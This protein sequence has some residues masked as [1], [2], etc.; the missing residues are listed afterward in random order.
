MDKTTLFPQV[1]IV[2]CTILAGA[3]DARTFRIPNLLTVPLLLS[4][5]IYHSITG[6]IADLQASIFGAV[7]GFGIIFVFYLVGGMGAGD[8][9]LMAAIGAWLQ[10]PTTLHVFVIAAILM[11]LYSVAMLVWQKRL[12]DGFRTVQIVLLR[13]STIGKHIGGEDR[14]EVHVQR[15]EGYKRLIPF[16]TL[17]MLAVI[18]LMIRHLWFRG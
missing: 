9:K 18:G 2:V 1:V 14:V 16:A 15:G 17:L 10:L 7:F 8:I 4:G 6:G 3:F 11:G 13:F 5:F 12:G